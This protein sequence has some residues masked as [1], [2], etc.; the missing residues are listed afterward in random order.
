MRVAEAAVA[1]ANAGESIRTERFGEDAFSG[2]SRVEH[3]WMNIVMAVRN[4]TRSSALQTVR[5]GAA[6][7]ALALLG[8]CES[9]CTAARQSTFPSPDQAAQ[10]LVASLRPLDSARLREVLGPEGDE[11]ISSGD[12][13]ADREG[14]EKFLK[15]YDEKHELVAEPDGRMTLEVG[16][17]GWPMPIPI[18]QKQRAWR[19]DTRSG[20][21]EILNRRIGRNELATIQVCLAIVDA[22]RDYAMLDSDGKGLRAYAQGFVSDAGKKNGLY[23]KTGENE[24]PSPLGPLVATASEEGYTSVRTETGEPQPYHGYHYRMLTSQG[25][26]AAGG[27]RDYIV[28]GNMTEGFAVVAWPAEY[29]NSGVMTFLVNHNGVVFQRDLGRKTD[30]TAK[31]MPAFDPDES[32]KVVV[33]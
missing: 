25:P 2:T 11:I 6:L 27:K 26:N 22:Q 17:D 31:A 7:A 28:K 3:D 20:K 4:A 16:K 10:V 30:R 5:V 12:E 13:V 29:G 33:E 8:V 19:F 18:V 32:W 23:W 14:I 15:A 21:D 1:V 24:P 9:G